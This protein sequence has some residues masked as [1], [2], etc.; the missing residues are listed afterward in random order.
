MNFIS[1]AS[2]RSDKL[3]EKIQTTVI[4][5]Q[6]WFAIMFGNSTLKCCQILFTATYQPDWPN[7]LGYILTDP[8]CQFFGISTKHANCH[9]CEIGFKNVKLHNCFYSKV[10]KYQKCLQDLIKKS[11][12]C[13]LTYDNCPMNLKQSFISNYCG[14][15]KKSKKKSTHSLKNIDKLNTYSKA[16]LSS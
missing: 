5:V 4:M 9:F 14:N 1:I 13:V 8:F 16:S 15:C 6:P 7:Y 10:Q 3:F 2:L 12:C 11:S